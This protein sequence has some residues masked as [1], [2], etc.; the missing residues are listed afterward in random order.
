MPIDIKSTT[1]PLDPIDAQYLTQLNIEVIYAQK[2]YAMA[3][4]HM[5]KR[6]NT[7]DSEWQLNNIETG[8]ERVVNVQA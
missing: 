1:I 3:L 6:Y 4:A 2:A 8:F 7:P 5:R